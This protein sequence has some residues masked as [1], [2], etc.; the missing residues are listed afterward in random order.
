MVLTINTGRDDA[1]L[2]LGSWMERRALLRCDFAFVRGAFSVRARIRALSAERVHLLSDDT[3]NE[4]VIPLTPDLQF[5][6]GDFR[7]ESPDD[8]ATYDLCLAIFIPVPTDPERP[9]T[10]NI[11]EVREE[12]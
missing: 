5:G 1:L 9:E 3:F 10:I 4:L 7:R 11:I 8:A 2:L 12:S 6:T